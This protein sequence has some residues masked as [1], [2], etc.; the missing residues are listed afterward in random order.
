MCIYENV[1]DT[2]SDVKESLVYGE[3]HSDYG[4]LPSVKI[5]LQ[6]K[7]NWSL[8]AFKLFCYANLASFKVPKK[9]E[10]VEFLE[11]TQSGKIMRKSG[12]TNK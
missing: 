4:Q 6:N 8:A 1:I 2:Y 3:E 11:K 5:V 10:V 9:V 12:K 7:K